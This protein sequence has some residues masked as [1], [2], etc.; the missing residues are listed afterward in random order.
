MKKFALVLIVLCLLL[1]AGCA[2]P[3]NTAGYQKI[4]PEEAKA[5][6]DAGKDLTLVDVRTQ[7]EYD[8]GHIPGAML[9]PSTDI[10]EKAAQALPDKS[11]V[12]LVYCRSGARSSSAS[13]A[14]AAMGYTN[15]YDLGGIAAWPYET[16]TEPNQ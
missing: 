11:A 6:L 3:Q 4:T 1:I 12:L 9:L 7:E 5:M 2:D 15:V 13:K 14:L 8:Q 10:Q 16:T